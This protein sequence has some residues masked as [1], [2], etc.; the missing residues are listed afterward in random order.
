MTGFEHNDEEETY[1][2][3]VDWLRKRRDEYRGQQAKAMPSMIAFDTIDKLL[4]E[5]RDTGVEGYLPWQ[6]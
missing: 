1:N 6:R 2:G 4:D 5:V 3:L